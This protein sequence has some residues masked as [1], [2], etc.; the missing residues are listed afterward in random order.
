MYFDSGDFE[1]IDQHLESLEEVKGV[2]PD[3]IGNKSTGLKVDYDFDR[4]IKYIPI[5]TIFLFLAIDGIFKSQ[6]FPTFLYWVIFIIFII[7]TAGYIWIGTTEKEL[8]PAKMQI[9]ISTIAFVVWVFAIGGPFAYYN[10]W[11]PA[12][13]SIVLILFSLLSGLYDLRIYRKLT[14]KFDIT[15]L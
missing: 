11:G 12:Y 2:A 7:A 6:N 13:G 15:R 4:F 1:K 5:E 14:S 8:P 9:A 3:K 10:W